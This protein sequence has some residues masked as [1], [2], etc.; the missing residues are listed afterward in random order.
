M[1][2][3]KQ[4]A[5]DAAVH[6]LNTQRAFSSSETNPESCRYRGPN[7]VKC[8]VGFLIPDDRYDDGIENSHGGTE[9]VCSA[10]SDEFVRGR[11]Q[12]G[13]GAFVMQMQRAI[14]DTLCERLEGKWD[15]PLFEEAVA[16]FAKTN[17]LIN[18]LTGEK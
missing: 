11:F 12:Y 7:G 17:A 3:D 14:H 15:Q 13:D 1:K 18:P 16:D 8:A 9:E 10:I 6:G 4:A 5:F 2:I